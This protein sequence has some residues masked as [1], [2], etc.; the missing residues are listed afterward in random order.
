MANRSVVEYFKDDSGY[1]CGYCGNEDTSLSNGKF[2]TNASQSQ[3][4]ASTRSGTRL[5]KSFALDSLVLTQVS[6]E[7]SLVTQ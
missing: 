6:N 3:T 1:K 7:Y 5:T 2:K 4:A